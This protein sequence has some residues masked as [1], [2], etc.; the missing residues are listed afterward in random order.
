MRSQ[1][2]PRRRAGV[3]VRVPAP[4]ARRLAATAAAALGVA[5]RESE[6]PREVGAQEVGQVGAIRLEAKPAFAVLAEAE[7]VVE[8]VALGIARDLVQR[9]PGRLRVEGVVEEPLDPRRSRGSRS[10]G[11]SLA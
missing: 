9:A 6:L 3:E 2:W 1:T 11:S 7:V 8:E 10:P 4:A 5:E